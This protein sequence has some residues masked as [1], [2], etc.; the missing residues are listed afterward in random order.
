MNSST[1]DHDKANDINQFFAN[2]GEEL[3]AT[4]PDCDE[5]PS[6]EFIYPPVFEFYEVCLVEIASLVSN[7]SGID[8]I[9]CHLIKAAG[10]SLIP[11]LHFL[12]NS[13]I[14]K[15]YFP[16]S[17]CIGC[18]TPFPRRATEQIHQITGQDLCYRPLEK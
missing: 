12:I 1:E 9:S 5:N 2:I 8:G 16:L 3:A 7:S 18:V 11:V 6:D 10:P 14:S 4:I 13:S 17:W 15:G